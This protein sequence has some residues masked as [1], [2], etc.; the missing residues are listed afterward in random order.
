[1]PQIGQFL[2][3]Y[4]F[5]SLSFF[6]G[7]LRAFLPTP[8]PPPGY[9]HAHIH[10][11]PSPPYWNTATFSFTPE[12]TRLFLRLSLFPNLSRCDRFQF[13]YADTLRLWEPSFSY[14]YGPIFELLPLRMSFSFP[15]PFFDSPTPFT[16]VDILLSKMSFPLRALGLNPSFCSPLVLFS[17]SPLSGPPR[18]HLLFR[19]L[20]KTDGCVPSPKSSP[21]ILR[22][23]RS[24]FP[25]TAHQMRLSWFVWSIFF[26]ISPIAECT[27]RLTLFFLRHLRKKW[28][29]LLIPRSQ[30]RKLILVLACF[31]DSSGDLSSH[32]PLYQ[33]GFS[34][35]QSFREFS[36]FLFQT[37]SKT[38]IPSLS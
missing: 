12:I 31:G 4:R 38:I 35:I 9:P 33:S 19:P 32:P 3:S 37:S 8:H 29:V 24:L 23:A 15:F 6:A 1:L 30:R 22:L 18:T 2:H 21:L 11:T 36:F 7:F 16:R 34:F 13:F 28:R 14:R 10:P 25:E 27:N 26:L 5:H 17:Q 20:D